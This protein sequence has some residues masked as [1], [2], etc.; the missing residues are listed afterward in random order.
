MEEVVGAPKDD[1]RAEK[2]S[3]FD[4]TFDFHNKLGVASIL[5]VNRNKKTYD[6]QMYMSTVGT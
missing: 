1:K 4:N 5:I 3:Y 6:H 2:I